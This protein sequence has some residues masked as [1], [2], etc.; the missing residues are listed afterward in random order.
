M[1]IAEHSSTPSPL[2]YTT[3]QLLEDEQILKTRDNTTLLHIIVKY[4]DPDLFEEN[5]LNELMKKCSHIRDD[6]GET[7]ACK[8]TA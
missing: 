1:K 4:F 6:F 2:V 5:Y 3:L 7:P 8:L